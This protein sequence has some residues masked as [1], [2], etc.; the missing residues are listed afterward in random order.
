VTTD[1]R[2]RAGLTWVGLRRVPTRRPQQTEEADEPRSRRR[3][4]G[5]LSSRGIKENVSL[6]TQFESA[7]SGMD[8][9]Q[10]R[11]PEE[12]PHDLRAPAEPFKG[13]DGDCIQTSRVSGTARAILSCFTFLLAHSSGF[14]SDEYGGRTNS[15]SLPAGSGDVLPGF[16][17]LVNGTA[18]D[19]QEARP[20]E[21]LQQLR[22]EPGEAAGAHASLVNLEAALAALTDRR[23]CLLP[24]GGPPGPTPP[25]C[26]RREPMWVPAWQSVRTDASSAIRITAPAAAARALI[27][28]LLAIP[29]LYPGGIL[30]PGPRP[31]PQ[32]HPE[33][34]GPRVL[35][36]G[37]A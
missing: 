7:L 19:D 1:A 27:G 21:V 23:G 26:S 28:E 15:S 24:L 31:R 4:S 14:S 30:L 6:W 2:R 33:P 12:S 20:V 37:L 34:P 29:P 17:R 8:V 11:S 25:A 13:S 32:S 5:A 3:N 10:L 35:A 36:V 22:R 9:I 18:V 16:L